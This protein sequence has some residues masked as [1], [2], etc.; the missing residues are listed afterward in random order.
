LL[1]HALALKVVY[2]F[3]EFFRLVLLLG[4]IFAANVEQDDSSFVLGLDQDFPVPHIF[5]LHD[6]FTGAKYFLVSN[7]VDVY[8]VNKLPQ[9][10]SS[11]VPDFRI[12]RWRFQEI[13]KPIL[14]AIETF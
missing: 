14:P 12:G 1:R 9:V 2:E 13:P 8:L 6:F 4:K 7:W 11:L 5:L 3:Y 10:L